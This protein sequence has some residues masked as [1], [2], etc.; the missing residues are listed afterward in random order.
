[1]TRKIKIGDIFI[2]GAKDRR[3][4]DDQH[5]DHGR[6]RHFGAAAAAQSGGVRH[7]ALFSPRQSE[8]GCPQRDRQ[9]LRHAR[10]SRHTFRLSAR[11]RR[12]AGG[13]GE[14]THQSRQHRRQK[15]RGISRRIPQRAR[16][17][18]THRR[19]RRLARKRFEGLP[20]DDAMV[21]SALSHASCSKTAAFTT[22]SSRSNRAMFGRAFRHTASCRR[23]ATIRCTS[24]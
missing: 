24:A 11:G 21:E 20:L 5:Q 22:P 9:R 10:R 16:R 7:R 15:E 1:M 6:R 12:G 18:D 2:G 14:D 8:R 13:R 3:P 17:P 19:Q 23:D 4:I